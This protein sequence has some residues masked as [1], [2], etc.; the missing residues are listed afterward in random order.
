MMS[1]GRGEEGVLYDRA[2]VRACVVYFWGV[3]FGGGAIGK[4]GGVEHQ[5]SWGRCW[6]G[7]LLESRGQ[8]LA[9]VRELGRR[10]REV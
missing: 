8:W 9:G 3:V 2:C 10:V 1:S 7:W 6:G 4:E 5:F